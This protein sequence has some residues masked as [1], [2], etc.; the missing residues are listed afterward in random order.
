MDMNMYFSFKQMVS[1]RVI[2]LIYIVGLIVITCAGGFFVGGGGVALQDMPYGAS[3][4]VGLGILTG[5]NLLWR[6]VCEA[7]ILLFS[8]HETLVSIE[9]NASGIEK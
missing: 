3:F 4:G 7:W 5:G 9:T 1:T 6:L 2:K 8:M